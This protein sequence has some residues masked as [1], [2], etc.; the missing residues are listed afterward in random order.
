VEP[1]TPV[2]AR[3]KDDYLKRLSNAGRKLPPGITLLWG[4]VVP[5]IDASAALIMTPS[6]SVLLKRTPTVAN[7]GTTYDVFTRRGVREYQL[8]M[9]ASHR[10]VGFGSRFAY[11]AV[12]DEDGLQRLQQHRWP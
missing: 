12:T 4:D 6:G 3:E 10:I 11:V 1:V 2:T 9:P 5:P 7:P 8:A